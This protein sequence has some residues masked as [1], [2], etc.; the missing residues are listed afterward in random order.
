MEQNIPTGPPP[1]TATGKDKDFIVSVDKPRSNAL[2]HGGNEVC[3]WHECG[4]RHRFNL[5]TSPLL[6][7]SIPTIY[8]YVW[9]YGLD[10]DV[11]NK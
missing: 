6:I 10:E 4:R 11:M 8:A 7:R 1:I 9:V 3:G 5:S 2:L